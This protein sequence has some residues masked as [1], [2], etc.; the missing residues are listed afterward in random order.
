MSKFTRR[1]VAIALAAGMAAGLS[2]FAPAPAA[3]Q[4]EPIRV[5]FGDIASIES[6]NLLIAIERT[7]EQGVPVELTFF[8]SEDVAAQAVVSGEADIGVGAPYAFLQNSGAPVR[9]FFRMSKLLFFPV[10]NSEVYS[11]WEDLDGQ[12]VTVHSRGSGTEALMRLMEQKH[13]ISYSNI[14]Y[15]PGAEVRAGAMLQG[16]VNATIVDAASW[17]LLESEGGGKFERLPLEGVDATD[18]ALYASQD[19]LEERA[20]D[21][22]VF[23]G[24]LLKT[25]ADIEENPSMVVE[26]REQYDLLPDLPGDATDEIE[27][28][29]TESVENGIYPTDGGSPENA[30]ADLEFLSAAGQVEASDD[31]NP[32]DYWDFGPLEAAKSSLGQN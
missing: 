18:E 20:E 16:T 24:E 23:V 22:T 17:R 14:S 21:V 3:A 2:S 7:K 8:N 27:T 12:E 4:D 30:S 6:L 1:T 25:W 19:F 32:E 15:V 11:G 28:Y 26:A 9:M 31:V 5:A 29:Y 10:V 13:G